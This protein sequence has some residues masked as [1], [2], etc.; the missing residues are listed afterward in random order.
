[1]LEVES[2]K[3][4]REGALVIFEKSNARLEWLETER[5]LKVTRAGF[6]P[7]EVLRACHEAGLEAL[8][9]NGATRVLSDNRGFAPPSQGVLD[10]I[11]ADWLPRMVRAGWRY[12]AVLEPA[13]PLGAMSLRRLAGIYRGRGITL[14]VFEREAEALAWLREKPAWS[15][16]ARRAAPGEGERVS[17]SPGPPSPTGRSA[18][19]RK[20]PGSGRSGAGE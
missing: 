13:T 14:E 8:A 11:E 6:V 7:A 20:P 15:G 18:P 17:S 4:A 19:R 1:M 5:V 3:T 2:V 12:W 16:P 10:W 9:R